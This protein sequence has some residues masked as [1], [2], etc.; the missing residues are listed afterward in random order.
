MIPGRVVRTSSIYENAALC[1]P[2]AP[3]E[4]NRPYLN[5]VAVVETSAAEPTELLAALKKTER[6]LGRKAG[7]HWAPREIDIDILALDGIH[8]VLPQLKIPHASMLDR[9]FV[10]IPFAEVWPEWRYPGEGPARGKTAREL[11]ECFDA[12]EV[13]LLEKGRRPFAQV[14]GIL[15]ITPDSF[16]DGGRAFETEAALDQARRLIAAGAWALDIGAESTR[17][18]ATPV[19]PEDEWRR[20]EP[21]LRGLNTVDGDLMLSVDTRH[22][23]TARRAAELGVHWI[24]DVEGFQDA[25]MRAAVRDFPVDLVVMHS[26]GVPPSRERVLSSRDPAGDVL[27]WAERRFAELEADGIARERLIFDPGIGF[28]KTPGGSWR[29][30]DDLRRFQQLGVRILVGH[31]RKSFLSEITDLPFAER[32]LETAVLAAQTASA[33]VDYFRVHDAGATHRAL[34]A[35]ARLSGGCTW[36]A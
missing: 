12:A 21:V 6:T 25:R 18:G 13:G 8:E 24:N 15:N 20:L 4:W 5:L 7:E 14:V 33:G 11:A 31:S 2:G 10:M 34:R 16:S 27:A 22:A 1:P 28:G 9:A 32:D 36:R 35:A 29:L 17:P 3:S 30:L 26:L 19:A 23:E